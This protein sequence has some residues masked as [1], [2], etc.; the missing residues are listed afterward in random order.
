MFRWH[1]QIAVVVIVATAAVNISASKAWTPDSIAFWLGS[2][3]EYLFENDIPN[4]EDRIVKTPTDGGIREEI[5]G[6]YR[7]R[8][9]KWKSELLST[10]LGRAQW[11][12]YAND[13]SFI[14]TITVAGGG[15]GAGTSDYL[16]ND[17][18]KLVGATIT[19]SASLEEGSPPPVYYPVLNSVSNNVTAHSIGG[20]I[21]AATRM[22]HELGHVNQTNEGSMKVIQMQNKLMIQYNSIFM[23]N[24]AK[25]KKLVDIANE[26]NG[27]PVEIWESREYWSEVNAML[28]LSQRISK[29]SF[30]CFVFRKMK[31]NIE[32]HAKAYEDRFSKHP[33][34][35]DSPCWN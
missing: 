30:Y 24:G 22:S 21:I 13:K 9:D 1:R 8:F 34:F 2:H 3:S 31:R 32:T 7:E 27:T 20:S 5:P 19:L 15:K 23:L 12:R 6:K 33:E 25:D 17:E 4:T 16:W 18:G 10:D 26:M 35:T 29:E 28:Y 14:L 11:E